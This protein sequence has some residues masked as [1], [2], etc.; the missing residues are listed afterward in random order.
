MPNSLPITQQS[1]SMS[2]SL[3]AQAE[4][5]T[6]GGPL[7]KRKAVE[8]DQLHSRPADEAELHYKRMLES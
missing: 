3:T 7:K 8:L 5:F 4:N 1:V 2:P 6:P